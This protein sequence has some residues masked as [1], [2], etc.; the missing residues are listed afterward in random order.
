MEVEV[1]V[2]GRASVALICKTLTPSASHPKHRLPVQDLQRVQIAHIQLV[3]TQKYWFTFFALQHKN[4]YF[5][6]CLQFQIKISASIASSSIN[7]DLLRGSKWTTSAVQPPPLITI[8]YTFHF[9]QNPLQYFHSRATCM[10]L[11][12]Q[13]FL[14]H[15]SN[16]L[17]GAQIVF[18]GCIA[19]A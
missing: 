11:A 14:C 15:V 6:H 19:I 10:G 13:T 2:G 16:F 5:C 18:S 12:R 1:E 17:K 8:C 3:Y 9:I 4:C 7:R